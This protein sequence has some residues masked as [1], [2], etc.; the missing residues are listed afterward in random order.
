MLPREYLELADLAWAHLGL[1]SSRD[2]S[3]GLHHVF[4]I[5]SSNTYPRH[6]FLTLMVAAQKCELNHAITF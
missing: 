5:L 1:P 2:L 3:P 4:L 6:A